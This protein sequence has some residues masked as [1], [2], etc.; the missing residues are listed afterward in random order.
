MT[1]ELPDGYKY[2]TMGI[3]V[4][5]SAAYGD[6]GFIV[7]VATVPLSPGWKPILGAV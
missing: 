6:Y 5:A 4:T 1:A 2:D 3:R 7:E